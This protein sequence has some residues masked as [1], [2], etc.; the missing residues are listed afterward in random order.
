MVGS[1]VL[2]TLGL[3]ELVVGRLTQAVWY[4]MAAL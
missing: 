2:A 3:E 4:E 1:M